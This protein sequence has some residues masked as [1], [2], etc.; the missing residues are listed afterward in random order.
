MT[1]DTQTLKLIERALNEAEDALGSLRR[2]HGTEVQ[3]FCYP[4]LN[5][6]REALEALRA[7]TDA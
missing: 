4:A 1:M 5:T 3:S 6:I 2:G 7:A